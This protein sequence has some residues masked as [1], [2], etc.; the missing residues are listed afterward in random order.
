MVVSVNFWQKEE[1]D[2]PI[3]LWLSLINE[4]CKYLKWKQEGDLKKKK[5]QTYKRRKDS[6]KKLTV[7]VHS[8]TQEKETKT[9][10]HEEPMSLHYALPPPKKIT[11]PVVMGPFENELE[12]LSEK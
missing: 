5:E 7:G 3:L 4:H 9:K 11:N 1:I 2:T 6:S 8:P 12:E 10:Q